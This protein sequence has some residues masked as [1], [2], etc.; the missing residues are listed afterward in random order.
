MSRKLS[1][2]KLIKI[3]INKANKLDFKKSE[4]LIASPIIKKGRGLKIEYNCGEI[5]KNRSWK[6]NMNIV[7]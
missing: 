4:N 6:T 3:K 2:K 7:E 1:F 5:L